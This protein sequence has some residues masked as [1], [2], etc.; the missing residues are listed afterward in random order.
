MAVRDAYLHLNELKWNLKP[1]TF[2][3]LII[4]CGGY[5][6]VGKPRL[7][8]VQQL[9]QVPLV[10]TDWSSRRIHWFCFCS[11]FHALQYL[12]KPEGDLNS[13]EQMNEWISIITDKLDGIRYLIRT[14]CKCT[15]AR[16]SIRAMPGFPEAS[17]CLGFVG[18]G[19]WTEPQN[20]C[21]VLGTSSF[22]SNVYFWTL[23]NLRKR[24]H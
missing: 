20:N 18:V 16:S 24:D 11:P 5:C 14:S 22:H 17:T 7:E 15:S 8:I 23:S 3:V 13:Y 21:P 6:H 12:P 19:E 1:A 4:P 9:H 2:Q 10:G